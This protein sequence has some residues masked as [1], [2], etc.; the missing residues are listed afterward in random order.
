MGCTVEWVGNLEIYLEAETGHPI[1][2]PSCTVYP[3]ISGGCEKVIVRVAVVP[4]DI[5]RREAGPTKGWSSG[6]RVGEVASIGFP[7]WAPLRVTVSRVWAIGWFHVTCKE[8]IV[9]GA[10]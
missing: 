7:I 4:L 1:L 3:V 2:K 9:I 5:R 6:N 10:P 8:V